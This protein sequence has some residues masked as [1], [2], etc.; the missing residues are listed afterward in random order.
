MTWDPLSLRAIKLLTR[1]HILYGGVSL[2][3]EN[4]AAVVQQADV[5]RPP[6]GY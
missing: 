5:H 6:K 2:T 3:G 1:G 4:L